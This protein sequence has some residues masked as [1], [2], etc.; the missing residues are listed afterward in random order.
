[1]V[2]GLC[3][4]RSVRVSE[5]SV[6]SSLRVTVHGVT[7]KTLAAS[8][9]QTVRVPNPLVMLWEADLIS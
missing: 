7:D 4:T 3:S 6:L 2:S 1:M 9:R 8:G 5:F